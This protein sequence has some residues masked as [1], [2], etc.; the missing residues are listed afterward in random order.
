MKATLTERE[1]QLQFDRSKENISVI[2]AMP[3]YDRMVRPQMKALRVAAYCRVSTLMEQQLSDKTAPG[4][5]WHPDSDRKYC[6]AGNC[7][8]QD[9]GQ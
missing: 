7:D 4:N 9:A 6:M 8:R 1:P 3:A 2:P 5:R